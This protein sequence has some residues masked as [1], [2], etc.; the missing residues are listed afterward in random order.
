MQKLSEVTGFTLIELL[1]VVLII[2]ILSAVALPQYQKAVAKARVTEGLVAIDTAKKQINMYLL[3]NGYPD[4][5]ISL[6]FISNTSQWNKLAG[7]CNYDYC[8]VDFD[9]TDGSNSLLYVL[10][11][12]HCV[13]ESVA[14]PGADFGYSK[15]GS[16]LQGCWTNKTSIGKSVCQSLESQGWKMIDE[17]W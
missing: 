5:T 10:D 15:N 16:W 6:E 7:N 2:G 1:V 8:T 3:E 17:I 12:Y 9:V 11:T 14:C 13:D 4:N